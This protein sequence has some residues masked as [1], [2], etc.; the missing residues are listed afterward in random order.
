MKFCDLAIGQKFVHGYGD[1]SVR[2][3]EKKSLSSAYA[4]HPVSLERVALPHIYARRDVK[5]NSF[6]G[7]SG[8]CIV[9]AL[10]SK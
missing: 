4:L 8:A 2:L 3:Y 10:E 6:V 5:G 9:H 1:T 7:F